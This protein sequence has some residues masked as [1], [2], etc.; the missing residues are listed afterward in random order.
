MTKLTPR[1]DWIVAFSMMA[2]GPTFAQEAATR[3]AFQARVVPILERYCVDCHSTDDAEAGIV[4]DRFEDQA[5]AVEDGRTWLRVRDALEGHAM[6]PAGEARPSPAELEALLGWIDADFLAAQ[7]GKQVGSAPVVI[8]RLNRQE[9]NNT[10]RD[11][12]GVDLRLADAFPPDDI[13][14]GFDNVGSALN[15]SPSHVEK[16]LDAAEL[17]LDRAIVVPDASRAI[18]PIELI[19]LKTY[20]LLAGEAGRVQARAQ[21]RPVSGPS[22]AWCGS[23]WRSRS[24]RRG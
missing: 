6:P 2:V 8:R 10:I 12:L 13:G 22:S 19:G 21:A 11:L 24:R 14:F 5:A 7:R 4:L 9:Y 3:D 17:A 15:I 23:G 16:Y 1:I 18:R 20:P